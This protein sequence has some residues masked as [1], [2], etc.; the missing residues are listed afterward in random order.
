M[1]SLKLGLIVLGA[2]LIC[3]CNDDDNDNA[4]NNMSSS[5]D[6]TAYVKSLLNNTSDTTDPVD[7][8]SVTLNSTNNDDPDA[9]NSVLG[10]GQ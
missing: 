1:K 7:I 8:N 10:N 6:F 5:S 4:G 3:A 9:Y 2:V